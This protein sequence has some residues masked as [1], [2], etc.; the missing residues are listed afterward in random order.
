MKKRIINVLLVFTLV[1][2]GTVG[3]SSIGVLANGEET[4]NEISDVVLTEDTINILDQ[5]RLEV[6]KTLEKNMI[7]S[8][9][10]A[11][12]P[13]GIKIQIDDNAKFSFQITTSNYG[14]TDEWSSG[15]ILAGA[16][17]AEYDISSS[18]VKQYSIVSSP[19]AG[20]MGSYALV[21][22]NFSISGNN[23]VYAEM[24]SQG[25][26]EGWI[27]AY[28]TAAAE[29]TVTVY[30]V[31]Q[32]DG[33]SYNDPLYHNVV[34]GPAG[35]DDIDTNY[36]SNEMVFLEMGHSYFVY[37]YLSGISTVVGTAAEADTYFWDGTT[38]TTITFTF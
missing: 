17:E 2:M 5:F 34:Y 38:Y 8:L 1:I 3:A 35:T 28:L 11:K 16:T 19:S 14:Q 23:D 7:T 20:S 21:G 6:A 15:L 18:L 27:E 22:Q 24:N 30:L 37:I 12:M 13:D 32:T 31:D 33:G 9:H 36:N 25:H 26:I 10:N 4:N 29:A